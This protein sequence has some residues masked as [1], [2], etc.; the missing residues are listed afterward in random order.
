VNPISFHQVSEILAADKER[1]SISGWFHSPERIKRPPP[2]QETFHLHLPLVQDTLVTLEELVNPVYLMR[3]SLDQIKD[4]FLEQSS[5]EL[6][7]FLKPE[8]FAALQKELIAAAADGAVVG[9]AN[10]RQYRRLLREEGAPE[11][12][13]AQL[14]VL[15]NVLRVL[16]SQ[17]FATLLA[18][19][20]GITPSKYYGE[21]RSFDH[22]HYTLIHDHSLEPSGVDVVLSCLGT[23]WEPAWGGQMVYMDQDE[24]LLS[25]FPSGNSLLVVFRDE[26]TMRFVKYVNHYAESSVPQVS[27]VYLEE[28]QEK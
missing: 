8:V 2:F 26:G 11:V 14:P 24:E 20:T 23:A 15:R 3:D 22:T 5:I 4:T 10:R 28:T 7:D 9:P 17:L 21:V 25:V 12:C 19:I 6:K 1:V 18:S 13:P 27:F 16:R